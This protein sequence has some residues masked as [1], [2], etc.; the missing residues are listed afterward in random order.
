MG[1]TIFMLDGAAIGVLGALLGVAG[2]LAFTY[3]INKIAD[4]IAS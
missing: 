4:F 3:N 2:G 1:A